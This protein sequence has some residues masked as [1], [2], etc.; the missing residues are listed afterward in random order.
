MSE[1]KS[2][3]SH[4]SPKADKNSI[5]S[6][7]VSLLNEDH[8]LVAQRKAKLNA[9]REEG[10]ATH[11]NTFRRTNWAKDLQ[12]DFSG[13]DKA[14][15]EEKNYQVSVSGRIMSKRGPFMVLQDGSEPSSYTLRNHFNIL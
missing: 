15:L 8:Q 1:S 9:L 12:Q 2:Q 11:P 10:K 6:Q 4:Q 3:Q 7:N 13:Y 14:Q 5:D